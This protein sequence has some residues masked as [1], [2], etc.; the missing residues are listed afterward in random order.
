MDLHAIIEALKKP[1]STPVEV[2]THIR[3]NT[4]PYCHTVKAVKRT[5]T[6]KHKLISAFTAEEELKRR[7]TEGY[8]PP[9]MVDIKIP[10]YS[11][12]ECQFC[13]KILKEKYS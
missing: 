7:G 4:C 1:K 13:H 2:D 8:H 5:T 9:N 10:V 6:Y 11:V 3:L 12:T